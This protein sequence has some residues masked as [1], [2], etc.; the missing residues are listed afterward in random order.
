MTIENVPERNKHTRETS[1][2]QS[3][4]N[5]KPIPHTL[6]KLCKDVGNTFPLLVFIE[7]LLKYLILATN[8]NH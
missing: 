2:I 8:V 5:R 7:N 6:S 3:Q 4:E 1:H